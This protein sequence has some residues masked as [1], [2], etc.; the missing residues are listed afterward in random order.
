MGLDT[1]AAV[2]ILP[3]EE[4]KKRFKTVPLKKSRSRLTTHTG[5]VVRPQGQIEVTVRTQYQSN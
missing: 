2:Y 5:E 4:Y 3:Y 1:G